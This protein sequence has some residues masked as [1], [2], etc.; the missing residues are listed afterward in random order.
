MLTDSK[1]FPCGCGKA[2]VD[3]SASAYVQIHPRGQVV[4]RY[5]QNTVSEFK[6]RVLYFWRRVTP[7]SIYK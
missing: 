1:S 3:R 7:Y 5:P 2:I 4:P 6:A